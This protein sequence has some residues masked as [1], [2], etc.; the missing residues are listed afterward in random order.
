MPQGKNVAY[1]PKLV[2]YVREHCVGVLTSDLIQ[3]IKRDLGMEVTPVTMRNLKHKYKLRSGVNCTFKKGHVPANKGQKMSAEQYEMCKA[4]MFKKGQKPK[5]ERP[6][7]SEYIDK[8]TYVHIKVRDDIGSGR[9]QKW[10]PKHHLLWMEYN[11]KEI[12][13]GHVVIFADGNKRNYDPDNLVLISQRE[14]LYL[15]Q[16]NLRYN[17]CELTK[18]GVLIAKVGIAAQ[19]R[20]KK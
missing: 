1:D 15:N 5:T 3:M 13:P 7:G 2:E 16:H 6:L 14:S 18:T 11:K 19:D 17:D 10:R 4:T 12:P 8:D 9:F 20:R